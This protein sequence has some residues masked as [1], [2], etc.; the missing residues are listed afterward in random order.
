M[1]GHHFFI[2]LHQIATP[3]NETTMSGNERRMYEQDERDESS[4]V[5]YMCMNLRASGKYRKYTV[6]S[7]NDFNRK[8]SA[9]SKGRTP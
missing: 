7:I 9:S 6:F 1:Y 8:E 3:M 2:F 4:D 5:Y